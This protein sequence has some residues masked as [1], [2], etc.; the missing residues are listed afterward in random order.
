[1]NRVLSAIVFIAAL[2]GAG[3]AETLTPADFDHSMKLTFSGYTTGETLT[4]FPALVNL[5][6]FV[7][8][9]CAAP[10]GADLRF[11]DSDGS[12]VIP[13]E[14]EDWNTNGASV[15]WVRVPKL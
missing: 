12:T 10:N 6:P 3:H 11:T 5:S 8:G 2:A 9:L 7:S 13:Y 1:M 4:N 14:V 15:V